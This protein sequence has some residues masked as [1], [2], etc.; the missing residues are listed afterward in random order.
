[1][2]RTVQVLLVEDSE[3]HAALL[4]QALE[5]PGGRVAVR[6]ARSLAE[7]RS[8]LGGFTPDLAIV[9]LCLPD[10]Q[11]TELLPPEGEEGAFPVVIMT[12]HGDEGVAVE[13]IKAGA[14]DYVVKTPASLAEMP[15]VVER[16][17]REWTQVT[18]RRRA[19]EAL[20]QSEERFRSFF[21]SA[22]SGMAIIS[23]EG[24][25]LRVNPT[26]CRL[27]GYSEPEALEKNILEVTHPDDREETRRLYDEIRADRRRV[28]DYEK[29]YLC[30]DGS[31][32]WGRATVAG[33]FGT[34]GALSYFA[35][36]VQ[37]ITERKETE[38]ALR[39]SEERFRTVFNNAAAGMVTLSTEGRFLEANEAFCRFIGY[40]REDLLSLRVPDITHPDDQEKTAENYRVLGSGQS[41]AIDYQKSFLR[42]DGST[43]WGHVSV[44]AVPGADGLPLYYVGLVQDITESKRV[45]DQIRESKQMLQLVL[46]Y[47]PQRVF[48]KDRDSVYLGGNRN[49]ARAAGVEAPQDLVG[50]TD[51]DLPWKREE[52]DFF[53]ECDRRVMESDAPELHIIEPQ[54]QASG[55]QA[56]L[57][58]S[59][60]PL[61]DGE[62]RVV[63]VLGTFEDFTERKR[64]EEALV[65][66]NRELDA[67]VYTVSHDL[68]TP[69]T[70]IIGYAEV[71]QE[72]CRDR[73][74][75][76]SLDCLA[77]IENQGRRMLA[78]MEDL[79]VL[80]KVGHVQRPAEPVDLGAVVAEVLVG[81]GSLLAEAG[82]AVERHSLPGLRVPKTL[83][84]QVFDNLI[85]NAV[86]YAGAEGASLEVGGE[87][88]GAMV[89]FFVRDHGP[90]IPAGE[91]E[92][93][94]E[95]FFRGT[96][97]K[98]VQGTG[99]GLATIQKIARCYGGRAWLEETP[100]GGCTFWVEMEDAPATGQEP[101]GGG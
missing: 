87:R 16:A 7:A 11:G 20:R 64:A 70:P 71:L 76:Q 94:F 47:I 26:F 67:F 59:K 66:A 82:V 73:L 99:V 23:P 55:K 92:R 83:L 74:D 21:E 27:S 14:L 49:F 85:G 44:A 60:V 45:Q 54:L 15:H 48:W 12:G 69:L 65:E 43:V 22:A 98:K 90:G 33:V 81:M 40:S 68:R 19:E 93:V 53:R 62:G 61:H 1:M 13:A 38:E 72:T 35:A 96:E 37:D 100:G 46:D 9:D 2:G 86:R 17:L 78:L 41:R 28:V 77:E 32:T 80:A 34:D 31:V 56:W 97:G 79:L 91:R 8:V 95:V 18:E 50:K 39:L 88:T 24:R 89:R 52:A 10:G 42:R 25:A 57:D 29:R 3:T 101:Q 63:G 58:T 30:K 36:N 84:A 51:Y 5:S 75:E 4:S 6:V